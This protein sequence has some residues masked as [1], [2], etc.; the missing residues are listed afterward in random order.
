MALQTSGQISLNDIH[1]EAGGSSG[2]GAS[3]NDAD[4]RGL[5]AAPGRFINTTPGSNIDFADFYGATDLLPMTTTNYMRQASSGTSQFAVYSTRSRAAPIVFNIGG[6]FYIRLRRQDPYVY[7][8]VREQTGA[9]SSNWYNTAGGV[10]S[11]STGYRTM[12]RFNVSGVQSV[13]LDWT[14]PT[15]SG[16]F[17]TA[18]AVG[19]TGG[20]ATYSASDNSFRSVSNG[21]SIGFLFKANCNAECYRNNV[22]NCYTFI[23]ARARKSGYADGV[24]GS[25]LLRARGNARATSCF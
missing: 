17:G 11:L 15:V 20:G 16:S 5:R 8:E 6:G 25:Y 13:A 3:I 12:G 21:R 1:R 4:I 18:Q 23:T 22:I 7:L 9:N 19:S 2:S 14:S 10:A 24:L